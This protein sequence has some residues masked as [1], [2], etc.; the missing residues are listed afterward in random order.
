M[1]SICWRIRWSGLVASFHQLGNE[2]STIIL[3]YSIRTLSM[4]SVHKAVLLSKNVIGETTKTMGQVLAEC[5][6]GVFGAWILSVAAYTNARSVDS[7]KVFRL[8]QHIDRLCILHSSLLICSH[9]HFNVI[10]RGAEEST[11]HQGGSAQLRP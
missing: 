2:E 4:A 7:T 1:G 3:L 6:R 11:Y 5:G 9:L 10:P 8:S